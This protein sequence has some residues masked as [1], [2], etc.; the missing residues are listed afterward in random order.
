MIVPRR[1]I[2]R[3][4]VTRL[5]D[6]DRAMRQDVVAV[7]EPLEIRVRFAEGDEWQTRSV[8]VTMRTPGDDF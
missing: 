7:E 5:R 4:R 3:L 2:T 8:S 1:R 6:R